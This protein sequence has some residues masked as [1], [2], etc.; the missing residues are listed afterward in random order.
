[1]KVKPHILETPRGQNVETVFVWVASILTTFPPMPKA[2]DLKL[3]LLKA[4]TNNYV[5]LCVTSILT[6][7]YYKRP[8]SIGIA[9]ALITIG[10]LVHNGS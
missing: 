7:F 1:M 4:K 9:W 2:W 6:C 10:K 3:T 5:N 8:G